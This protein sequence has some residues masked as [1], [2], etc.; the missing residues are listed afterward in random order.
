MASLNPCTSIDVAAKVEV[1]T[2][3]SEPT[4][5]TLIFFNNADID[6]INKLLNGIGYRFLDKD[7]SKKIY[8][9]FFGK[10]HFPDKTQLYTGASSY[11]DCSMLLLTENNELLEKYSGAISYAQS[12]GDFKFF[13]L[14]S[15]YINLSAYNE[16]YD[17]SKVDNFRQEHKN[18]ILTS[19]VNENSELIRQLYMRSNKMKIGLLLMRERI[20]LNEPFFENGASLMVVLNYAKNN[21]YR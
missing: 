19:M 16:V 1:N 15:L 17:V 4:I 12:L 14:E 8:S 10:R 13:G 20:G 9:S 11:L 2:L 5:E 7:K 18:P 21:Y 6:K 3:I